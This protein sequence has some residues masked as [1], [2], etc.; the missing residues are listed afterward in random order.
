MQRII[1]MSFKGTSPLLLSCDK[2]ADPLNPATIAHKEITSKRKKTEEDHAMIARSQWEGLM[3][4]SDEVGVYVPSQNIRA[5]IVGGAKLNKLGMQVKRGTIMGGHDHVP[6]SYGKKKTIDQ[7][8]DDPAYRDVR[9]VVI[10]SARVMAYRPKFE[11]WSLEFSMTYDDTVLDVNQIKQACDNAGMFVGIGGF[12]PEKGGP[13][14]RF[15]AL[16]IE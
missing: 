3:Y 9:S 6:L 4:W 5:T 10:S 1:T 16:I 13:F 14:G 12:R 15:E 2:M 11:N 8:W 7:L